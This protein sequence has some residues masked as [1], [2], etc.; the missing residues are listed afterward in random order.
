MSV[1]GGIQLL[2]NPDF[3]ALPLAGPV[4]SAIQREK[5]D[6]FPLATTAVD[7]Q[8]IPLGRDF[9][10]LFSAGWQLAG[11]MLDAG[12]W[13]QILAGAAFS[14]NGQGDHRDQG[15]YCDAGSEQ[16]WTNAAQ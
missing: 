2:A 8:I 15:Q 10:L 1:H 3:R 14:N 4:G 6:L 7:Q 5:Y 13:Q 11:W 16:D 9:C 12:C